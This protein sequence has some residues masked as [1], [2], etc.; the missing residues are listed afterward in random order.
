MNR[1]WSSR[2]PVNPG[3]LYRRGQHF[4]QQLALAFLDRQQNGELRCDHRGS[5]AEPLTLHDIRYHIYPRCSCT[6][7]SAVHLRFSYPTLGGIA[8][9]ATRIPSRPSLLHC[10]IHG[11]VE[12]RPAIRLGSG[13]ERRDIALEIPVLVQKLGGR[14]P[15]VLVELLLVL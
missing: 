12:N 11:L 15:T 13:A 4:L 14:R 6:R 3:R 10:P 1:A 8:S 2:S 7:V 9:A 5:Y